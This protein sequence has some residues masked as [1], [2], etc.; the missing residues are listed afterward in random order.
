MAPL[1]ADFDWETGMMKT[2]NNTNS[3]K[4][5]IHQ[6]I[7]ATGFHPVGDHYERGNDRVTVDLQGGWE[8]EINGAVSYGFGIAPLEATL[9]A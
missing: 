5:K 1:V 8:V 9:K 3:Y 4:A 7:R 6:V 2:K